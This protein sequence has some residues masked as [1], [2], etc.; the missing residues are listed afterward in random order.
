MEKVTLDFGVDED[1]ISQEDLARLVEEFG[2]LPNGFAF[3]KDYKSGLL[4]PHAGTTV[5][6]YGGVICGQTKESKGFYKRAAE[7]FT[8]DRLAVYTI[9][10]NEDDLE[11]VATSFH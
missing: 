9:P 10:E 4:K 11:A 3:Y 7:L 6:Y 1:F 8:Y 5:A 2:G